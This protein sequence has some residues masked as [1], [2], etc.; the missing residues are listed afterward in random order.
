MKLTT[1]H[2]ENHPDM[3]KGPESSMN[4][5]ESDG[6]VSPTPHIHTPPAKDD[7][8][9]G[10]CYGPADDYAKLLI[11]ILAATAKE[12]SGDGNRLGIRGHVL[13]E[14]FQNQLGSSESKSRQSFESIWRM[15]SLGNI[16]SGTPLGAGVF[17]VVNQEDIKGMRKKGS[18]QWGGMP[19][20]LSVSVIIMGRIIY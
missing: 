3:H 18:A 8:G 1:F 10:G 2:P 19:N 12:S 5:R 6:S 16:P 11:A 20:L 17:A 4:V 7:C 14:M 15:Y 9:G 13:A